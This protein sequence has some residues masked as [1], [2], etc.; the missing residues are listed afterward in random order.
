MPQNFNIKVARAAFFPSIQL[1]ASAG[2]QA[3][4][5]NKLI[6]PG[7][8][9]ASL[10]EGLTLPIF[11]GG[12][13]RGQ[14]DQ[15]KGRYDEL[16]ADYRKAVVQAFTDVDT[17][18]TAW[19]YTTEQ[20]KLQ[21]VAVETATARGRHRPGADGGR[22]RRHHHR[23]DRGDDAVQR[24]GHAGPGSPRPC[25]GAAQSVQGAGWRLDRIRPIAVPRPDPGMLQAASP[26]RSEETS[27]ERRGQT[28]GPS[29]YRCLSTQ[30]STAW[31]H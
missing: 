18:L 27:D 5:L 8:A 3:P 7:G 26:C 25:A 10:A 31:T 21:R 29:R 19:R 4:A 15:A 16:L 17:A 24:R 1:T 9:L 28:A 13:L 14:L 12:T 30:G 20:E 2:Y 6:T 22:D 23:A 11:D